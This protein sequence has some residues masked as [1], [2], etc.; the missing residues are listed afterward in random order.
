MIENLNKS[1]KIGKGTVIE[2]GVVIG[3][4]V[5]IGHNCTILEGVSIGDN[6]HI[7]NNVVLGERVSSF[8][9]ETDSHTPLP[10]VIGK[11][12]II[13]SG[14]ILYEGS[15]FGDFFQ[16]GCSVSIRERN[17]FGKGSMFGT[18]C[19]SECD[20]KVGDYSRIINGVEIGKNAN[21]GRYVWIFAHAVLTDDPHPPL[22]CCG[23]QAAIIEDYAIVGPHVIL[24]PHVKIGKGA[25][26][27]AGSVV[28]KDVSEEMLCLGTPAKIVG[29]VHD[30]RCKKENL[31]SK[32]GK[33][34]PWI[35]TII[36]LEEKMKRYNYNE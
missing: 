20:V 18:M 22:G 8:Y 9:D 34:Y 3:N 14:S 10:L 31:V 13:R 1:V 6:T 21:I 29:N 25:I 5:K 33:P 19:Q 2:S 32:S 16:T 36:Q 24:M 17:Y 7:S 35:D 4:N 26:I 11:N 15:V 28:T 12:C 30:I 23:I 27:G